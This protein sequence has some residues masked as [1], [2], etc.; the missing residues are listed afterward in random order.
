MSRSAG[1]PGREP[2]PTTLQLMILRSKISGMTDD[3]IARACKIGVRTVRR[4]LDELAQGIGVRG[5]AALFAEAVRRGWL[6]Q[7]EFGNQRGGP[8]HGQSLSD[9]PHRFDMSCF[10]RNRPT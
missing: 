2:T 6:E 4:H 3:A 10:G 5:R 1:Q 9:S 7:E 8:N